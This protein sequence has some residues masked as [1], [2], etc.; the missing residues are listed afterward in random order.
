MSEAHAGGTAPSRLGWWTEMLFALAILGL[1]VRVAYLFDQNG[2]LPQPFFYE[3]ATPS[4]TG[5]TPPTGRAIPEH[6]I[7]GERSTPR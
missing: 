3:P 1:L 6:M 5:S 7:R 2:Y 4:W